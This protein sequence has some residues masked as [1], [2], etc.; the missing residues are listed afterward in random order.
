VSALVF[1]A[2]AH[3]L[4][5]LAM[6][7]PSRAPA[8]A[9]GIA[10]LS[11][12]VVQPDTSISPVKSKL[13]ANLRKL[14]VQQENLELLNLGNST[15]C[16][17]PEWPPG[18]VYPDI[19]VVGVAKTGSTYM[20][21]LLAQHPRV[22]RGSRKEIE[23]FPQPHEKMKPV[24]LYVKH[25]P[26]R[27][28]DNPKAISIDASN[29]YCVWPPTRNALRRTFPCAKI[30]FL[31]RDPTI[32]WW[33]AYQHSQRSCRQALQRHEACQN[34][35]AP[36]GK[37][38]RANM[39]A[40]Q[41]AMR[42]VGFTKELQ[43]AGVSFFSLQ[44]QKLPIDSIGKKAI[45]AG[46]YYSRVMEWLEVWPRSQVLLVNTEE[47]FNATTLNEKM[48][49]ITDFAGLPPHKFKPIPPRLPYADGTHDAPG[50][51]GTLPEP[52]NSTLRA[53]Y[54]PDLKLLKQHFGISFTGTGDI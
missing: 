18:V 2:C 29:N 49:V 41:Q 39:N 33:S 40:S 9:P 12:A 19:F 34:P 4:L 27:T 6:S 36:V 16:I 20:Y 47:Y 28:T 53:Y 46:L 22:V 37:V 3:A 8:V 26:N 48:R 14:Q 23:F 54:E 42:Q 11:A 30:I 10:T 51:Y 13:P 21:S 31:M 52:Y 45:T 15:P 24:S 17:P 38:F 44:R 50:D 7:K 1:L 5:W 25:F 43:E 35:I 32:R